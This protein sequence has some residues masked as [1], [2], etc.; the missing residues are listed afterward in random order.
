MFFSI[1]EGIVLRRHNLT[2]TYMDIRF[3]KSVP[4]LKGLNWSNQ[5]NFRSFEFVDRDN[6]TQIQVTENWNLIV[7]RSKG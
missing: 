4:A 1:S 6:E 2:Y 5:G 3:G 7:K